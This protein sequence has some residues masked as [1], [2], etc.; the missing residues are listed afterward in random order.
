MPYTAPAHKANAYDCPHCKAYAR[1]YHHPLFT[2]NNGINQVDGLWVSYC[3]H[4]KKKCVWLDGEMLWPEN[5]PAPLPHEDMPGDCAEDYMEARNII[6]KSP[7]GAA[8]LL[9][10]VTQKLMPHLGERGKNID[11]D[12]AS[13]VKKGLPIQVQQALDTCRVIGNESVHPGEMNLDDEPEIAVQLCE[14][15]N[16]IVENQI[17]QPKRINAI[18]S[19][20]P[21]KKQEAIRRRDA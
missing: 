18:Y 13:L 16:F 17:A 8:A 9:R 1:Q 6:T 19:K 3:E 2:H 15:I 20:L 11:D 21:E 4:C 10:L 14:L 12:I 5:A 7:R